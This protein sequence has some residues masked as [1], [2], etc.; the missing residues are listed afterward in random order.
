MRYMI[1]QKR[2]F[3]YNCIQIALC[4]KR[5]KVTSYFFFVVMYTKLRS[6]WYIT[7]CKTIKATQRKYY[8]KIMHE[9]VTRLRKH[10]FFSKIHHKSKYCPRDFQ[11]LSK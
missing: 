5:L 3:I 8:H 10:I 9:F 4:A 7:H 1:A 11:F 6:F 2:N